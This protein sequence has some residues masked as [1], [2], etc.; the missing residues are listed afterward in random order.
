MERNWGCNW[1]NYFILA[2][3]VT[4]GWFE[5]MSAITPELCDTKSVY[6]FIVSIKDVNN[7][8]EKNVMQ[9]HLPSYWYP[10]MVI[11][12]ISFSFLFSSLVCS[13]LYWYC[14]EKFY[15]GHSWEFKVQFILLLLMD[16]LKL[17]FQGSLVKFIGRQMHHPTLILF[18]PLLHNKFL[19]TSTKKHLFISWLQ[20][21]CECFLL[22]IKKLF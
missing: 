16:S 17:W 15:L 19:N 14:K 4:Q 9:K 20:L 2:E 12:P 1:V 10:I 22:L 5:I 18:Y 6:Q 13:T 7:S 11:G 3:H 21:A 8:V